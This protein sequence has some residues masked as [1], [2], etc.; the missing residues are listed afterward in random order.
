[1]DNQNT[2]QRSNIC[3]WSQW[4]GFC[5][6]AGTRSLEGKALLEY[7]V[8][9]WSA[10]AFYFWDSSSHHYCW[11]SQVLG[12]FTCETAAVT[13]TPRCAARCT[14]TTLSSCN[15]RFARVACFASTWFVAYVPFVFT[16]VRRWQQ[17]WTPS[18]AA[19]CA[20]TTLQHT[21]CSRHWKRCWALT[22][23][24]KG[25]SWM[26]STLGVCVCESGCSFLFPSWD[27][28]RQGNYLLRGIHDCGKSFTFCFESNKEERIKTKRN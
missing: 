24:S 9:Q 16:P 4:W 26:Q 22:P 19:G 11:K 8:R 18:C 2:L 10:G 13:P 21:C 20:P 15:L 27:A 7:F 12:R 28:V 5:G 1:M 17:M 25:H 6:T 3:W 14:L 23:A